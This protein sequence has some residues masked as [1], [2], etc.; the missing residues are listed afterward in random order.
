MKKKNKGGRPRV[1]AAGTVKVTVTMDK[2]LL[3]QVDSFRS[4]ETRSSVMDKA[5]REFLLGNISNE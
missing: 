2:G 3:L 5:V 1:F 4:N